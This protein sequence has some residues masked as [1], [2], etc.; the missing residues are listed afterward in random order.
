MQLAAGAI[1]VHGMALA[2][3]AILGGV[4]AVGVSTSVGATPAGF[5]LVPLAAGSANVANDV[6]VAA[7]AASIMAYF[8][9]PK[10]D[11]PRNR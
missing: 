3:M 9:V 8:Y 5:N 1:I 11:V 7:L 4:A 6:T 2:W 10:H